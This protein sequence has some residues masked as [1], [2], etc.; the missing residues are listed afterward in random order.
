MPTRILQLT[1]RRNPPAASAWSFAVRSDGQPK[2]QDCIIHSSP[3]AEIVSRMLSAR[4]APG[5]VAKANIRRRRARCELS[6]IPAQIRRRRA[7]CELAPPRTDLEGMRRHRHG[8]LRRI[9]R[10]G[11]RRSQASSVVGWRQTCRAGH[12]AAGVVNSAR[13]LGG[14]THIIPTEEIKSSAAAKLDRGVVRP[15]VARSAPRLSHHTQGIRV[16]AYRCALHGHSGRRRMSSLSASAGQTPPVFRRP[17]RA[18][19]L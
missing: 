17:R 4:G 9:R 7:R 12:G 16:G 6:P 19:C 2:R 1:L 10:I 13:R 14:N 5:G 3:Q 18:G 15:A 11:F 8:V